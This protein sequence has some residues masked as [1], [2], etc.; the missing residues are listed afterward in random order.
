MP[1]WF[2]FF[3][4]SLAVWRLTHL[5]VKEDGPWQIISKIRR[6]AGNGFWGNLMD[7]FMCASIWVAVPFVFFVGG[8]IVEKLV[9]WLALSGT[10]IILERMFTEEPL[11]LEQGGEKDGMLWSDTERDERGGE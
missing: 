6:K 3:L 4:A 10:A 9:I 11:I 5:I 7:C 1:Y 8:T 2:R